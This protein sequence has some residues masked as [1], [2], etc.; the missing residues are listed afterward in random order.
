[1]I[2]SVASIWEIQIK[3]QIGKLRIESE[4]SQLIEN[5]RQTNNLHVLPVEC[6]HVLA[7]GPLPMV[8]RDPFDRILVAQANAI[9]ATLVSADPIFKQYGVNLLQ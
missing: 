6:D 5:Q 7:L 3:L 9:G 8:H 4:L 2:F 1:L